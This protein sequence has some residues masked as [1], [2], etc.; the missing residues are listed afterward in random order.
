MKYFKIFVFMAY[1]LISL[2][3]NVL[4]ALQRFLSKPWRF[5]FKHNSGNDHLNA[6]YRSY[7]EIA[8]IP[9]YILLIPLRLVNACYY[10]LIVHT[11]FEC[12]NYLYEVIA[13][14]SE[15][16]GAGSITKWL[17]WLPF[18]VLKYPL[19][20]GALT[21]IE[22][23]VWTI[24]DTFVPTLTLY[25]GTDSVASS[26]ITG[27][28]AYSDNPNPND[29]VWLVG[30][31][32]FSG[33][34]VYFVPSR[35]VAS[36]YSNGSIIVARVSLGRVL[37]LGLAPESIYKLCGKPFEDTTV[38]TH[39]G[40]KNKYVTGE[41]WNESGGYWEYCMYDY[42]NRYNHSWRIRPLY[43]LDIKNQFFQRIPGGMT[44]WL[45]RS[46]VIKDIMNATSRA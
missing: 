15:R 38:I 37:D 5:C 10:N 16:E 46:I 25:H 39:W 22:N 2:P 1:W 32:D 42:Q 23:V 18:R 14:S 8:K 34:G 17:L 9:L 35:S 6:T 11:L 31:G 4:N 7:L 27:D 33:K 21:L 36:R 44:H 24:I 41:R 45:F 29:G 40:L 12:Y 28:S 20:H 3:F 30:R 19:F 13:P 43:V 26:H